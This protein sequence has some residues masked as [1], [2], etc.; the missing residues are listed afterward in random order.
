MKRHLHD[1]KSAITRNNLI[2]VLSD[3]IVT[4]RFY[5]CFNTDGKNIEGIMDIY[6]CIKTLGY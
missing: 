5:Y 2:V 1:H 3:Y 6:V 4:N